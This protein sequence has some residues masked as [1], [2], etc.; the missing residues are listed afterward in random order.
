MTRAPNFA[1]TDFVLSREPPS[2]TTISAF[3]C[4]S[5]TACCTSGK[6]TSRFSCSFNAG[7][8]METSGAAAEFTVIIA[9]VE[10]QHYTIVDRRKNKKGPLNEQLTLFTDRKLTVWVRW[11][12]AVA[13]FDRRK[14]GLNHFG[15]NVIAV[16]LIQ[17]VSQKS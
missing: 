9:E 13:V 1:A 4:S 5:A 15:L 3:S 7:M 6:S 17:F 8:T 2:T 10:L 12:E 11:L 14:K 16:E